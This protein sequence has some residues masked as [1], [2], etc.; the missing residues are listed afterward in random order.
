VGSNIV[1]CRYDCSLD[2][3]ITS[4]RWGEDFLEYAQIIR[5]F[6][7]EWTVLQ[8]KRAN[9]LVFALFQ[10]AY[11]ESLFWSRQQVLVQLFKKSHVVM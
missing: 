2:G 8:S 4:R 10:K 3:I 11:N 7:G 1:G 5:I 9:F 6:L